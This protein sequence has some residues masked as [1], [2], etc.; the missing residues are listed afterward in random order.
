MTLRSAG[1][2]ALSAGHWWLA[3]FHP[4]M[5][6]FLLVVL[7]CVAMQE[8]V[9]VPHSRGCWSCFIGRPCKPHKSREIMLSIKPR[10]QTKWSRSAKYYFIDQKWCFGSRIRLIGE[11]SVD[12]VS[13]D[14]GMINEETG[15]HTRAQRRHHCCCAPKRGRKVRS[16][17][18]PIVA[19]TRDEWR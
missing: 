9:Q 11:I 5:R 19:R 7:F 15:H 18:I 10:P 8:K 13:S 12:V 3:T 4:A 16:T 1:T 6:S 2:R 14:G 17:R